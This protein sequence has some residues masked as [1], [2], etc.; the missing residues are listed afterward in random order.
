MEVDADVEWRNA[1]LAL[2]AVDARFSIGAAPRPE[3]RSVTVRKELENPARCTRS[4]FYRISGL[5][6]VPVDPFREEDAAEDEE[7]HSDL[8]VHTAPPNSEYLFEIPSVGKVISI[9]FDVSYKELLQSVRGLTGVEV[10]D[11]PYVSTP[12]NKVLPRMSLFN[13]LTIPYYFSQM[14][15]CEKERDDEKVS[16]NDNNTFAHEQIDC[17]DLSLSLSLY[18]YIYAFQKEGRSS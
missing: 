6:A 9:H 12:K 14:F 10:G 16:N 8:E 4:L 1:G 13:F 17:D 11:L 15:V 7:T 18:I 3:I 5:P 2:R